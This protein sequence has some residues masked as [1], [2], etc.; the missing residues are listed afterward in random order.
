MDLHCEALIFLMKIC[1]IWIMLYQ[2]IFWIPVVTDCAPLILD[3]FLCSDKRDLCL[4]SKYL[5][6]MTSQTYLTIP[7]KILTIYPTSKTLNLR[8]IIQKYPTE[9]QLNKQFPQV[10]KYFQ[11]HSSLEDL[12]MYPK[13]E[14]YPK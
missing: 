10:P 8:N 14:S 2:H 12:W 4:T 1:A 9:L 6:G 5:N 3:L 11:G 13:H 7:F